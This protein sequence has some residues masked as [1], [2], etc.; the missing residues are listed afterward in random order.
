ME[1]IFNEESYRAYLENHYEVMA[2]K[3]N[4][5]KRKEIVDGFSE[6][7]LQKIVDDTKAFAL[8]AL[9]ELEKTEISLIDS[10]FMKTRLWD[11]VEVDTGLIGGYEA[12]M[13]YNLDGFSEDAFVSNY[14]L[15]KFFNNNVSINYKEEE[16]VPEE[17]EEK[18]IISVPY[19]S[20][21]MKK[22]EFK[23]YKEYL[24]EK[25]KVMTKK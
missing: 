17:D 23:K 13:L 5:K 7:E 3:F 25:P 15:N 4:Y 6:E 20:I 10:V 16:F 21:V 11:A 14:L 19:L 24:A 2:D 12:D 9:G 1:K 8:Y 18:R 22:E